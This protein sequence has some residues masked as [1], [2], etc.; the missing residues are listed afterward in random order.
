MP[1]VQLGGRAPGRLRRVRIALGVAWLVDAALQL[2]PSMF[3][4]GFVTGVLAPAAAGQPGIVGRPMVAVDHLAGA[5]PVVVD[6]VAAL[7]QAAIG[8]GL[9]PDAT[10]RPA[11]A[12]SVAWAGG[13]WWFG[14]GFGG[15]LTG[16]ASPLTG[17]PGAAALYGLVAVLVRPTLARVTGSRL[18]R[19]TWA[20]L[21]A[22]TGLL[23]LQ[24]AVR[25]PGAT[26]DALATAAPGGPG[27]LAWPARALSD[28][29][30]G[31]GLVVALVG[32]LA[33]LAVGFGVLVP[34]WRRVALAAGSVVALA[35]WATGQAFGGVLTGTATDLQTGPLVV[36]VALA[37]AARLEPGGAVAR[38]P[39]PP[40]RAEPTVRSPLPARTA[41]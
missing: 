10:A 30:R 9:I 20:V 11:L 35:M 16:S 13:V 22:G 21:W 41:A 32:A 34:R 14:E 5:H 18:V 38:Q 4:R 3:G 28:A 37:A 7:V 24:P 19:G 6:V 1:D 27:W 15:L 40:E 23:W 17:A 36:L 25:A 2:Q 26:R 12:A 33:G 31:H 39:A 8:V 29:A